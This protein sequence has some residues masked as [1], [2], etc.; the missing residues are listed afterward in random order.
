MSADLLT[1]IRELAGS[2][3]ANALQAEF[4]GTRQ[5]IA[6][7]SPADAF[8]LPRFCIKGRLSHGVGPRPALYLVIDAATMVATVSGGRALVEVET[9]GLG[10]SYIDALRSVL[11]DA[12]VDVVGVLR[13]RDGSG[14]TA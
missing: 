6:G 4:G 13:I 7:K 2:S 3:V 14:A 10:D 9:R 5:Y 11:A 12:P 1:R 8:A